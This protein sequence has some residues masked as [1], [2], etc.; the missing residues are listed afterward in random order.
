VLITLVF[1]RKGHPFQGRSFSHA[2][3]NVH[4]KSAFFSALKHLNLLIVAEVRMDS[5]DIKF[6]DAGSCLARIAEAQGSIDAAFALLNDPVV[7]PDDAVKAAALLQ[8]SLQVLSV[9]QRL[10]HDSLLGGV[11]AGPG[12]P[13]PGK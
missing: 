13:T 4:S 2:A 1:S 3:Q 10:L 7:K 6:E 9:A 11:S 5:C 12:V 8:H